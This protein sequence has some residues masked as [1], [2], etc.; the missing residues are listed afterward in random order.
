MDYFTSWEQDDALEE[1]I[2]LLE[3]LRGALPPGRE[4]AVDDAKALL[5]RAA[6][7]YKAAHLAASAYESEKVSLYDLL[8]QSYKA[9]LEGY[10]K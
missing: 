8:P 10:I 4:S 5:I 7:L 3:K 9:L 6:Q 2:A 1:G